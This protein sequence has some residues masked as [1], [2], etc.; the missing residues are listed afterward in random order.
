MRALIV[1]DEFLIRM[2]LRDLL[3]EAGFECEEAVDAEQAVALL[4]G[5][6]WVPDLLVSDYNLG[7]GQNG[8]AL[9]DTLLRRLPGLAVVFI[10]GNPE[11]FANRAFGVRERLLA[12]PFSPNNLMRVV[13]EVTAPAAPP[14]GS[15]FSFTRAAA[16]DRLLRHSKA[17]VL[18]TI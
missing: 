6:T 16:L 9:A 2:L 3:D 13:R 12:K 4:D 7:P 10:T 8:M 11:C 1:E 18:A 17:P 15:I 5:G 14:T